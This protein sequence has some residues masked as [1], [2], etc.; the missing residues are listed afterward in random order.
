MDYTIDGQ[1][2]MAVANVEVAGD[3]E[4]ADLTIRVEIHDGHVMVEPADPQTSVGDIVELLVTSHIQEIIHVHGY[5]L[6]L[7]VGPDAPA[8]LRFTVDVV[9]IF[10]IELEQSGSPLL[11]LTVQ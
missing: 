10:E 7:P 6:M 1:L 9:G 2:I 5:D 8:T 11:E 3:V 4:A